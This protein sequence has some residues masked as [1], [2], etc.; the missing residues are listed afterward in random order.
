MKRLLFPILASSIIA[1]TLLYACSGGGG[2]TGGTLPASG[3]GTTTGS[4]GLYLTDDMSMYSQVTATVNKV[5]L[6]H[7]GLGRSCDL[8]TF[9][10][11]VNISNMAGIMQLVD[12][13][14]CPAGPYN[15]YR[16]LFD[17]SVQLVSGPTGT[18]TLCSFTDY[19]PQ[20][21]GSKPN[22][23]SCDANGI[24]TLDVTGA[25][26]VLAQMDTKVALDFDLKNFIVAN[27]GMPGCSVTMKVHPLTP[28]QMQPIIESVS[29]LVSNLNT[30]AMTFDLTTRSTRTFILLYT[31]NSS[32]GQPKLDIVLQRAQDEQLMTQVTSSTIDFSRNSI[33]AD[34]VAVKIA[35]IVSGNTGTSFTLTYRTTNSLV[36]DYGNAIVSGTVTD[37]SWVLVKLIGY[38]QVSGDFIAD[39]IEIGLM[40]IMTDN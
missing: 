31:G 39:K 4:V 6:I 30:T 22:K 11:S 15:R 14:Q 37:G 13:S 27:L 5:Q 23:L 8:L 7:T 24:C 3:A 21:M 25:V 36:V 40:G 10:V 9:P 29:G 20:G 32:T 28:I 16:I 18:P 2:G 1:A 19:S 17:K 26:N 38:D 35:G 34:K 12:V 33:T